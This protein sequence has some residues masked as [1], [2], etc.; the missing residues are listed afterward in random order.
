MTRKELFHHIKE[1]SSYLCVGL[2]TDLSKI[3]KHLLKENDPVF[4]FNKQIIDATID[5]CVGYKPNLAFYE[6]LGASGWESLQKT[7][8]YIPDEL[9]TIA[10]AKRGDIGN[11]AKKYAEAFF[12]RMNFDSVT[13]APYMGRDSVDPFLQYEGKWSIIL[14]LTSNESSTDFEELN[15]ESGIALFE[16]VLSKASS[17]GTDDQL[18]FVIGAT[19]PDKFQLVR[20]TIPNHF[21]LVP[22]IGAQGGDLDSISRIGFND[23]CGLLVNSSR[24]IIYASD[25]KNFG[26]SAKKA[27]ANVQRSMKALLENYM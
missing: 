11:T 21:L 13:I 19:K 2:D 27:A 25:D 14:G 12:E 24:S 6:S 10:D 23:H 20:K 15:L 3:P 1:K 18:M 8:E 17:W 7:I 16:E 4:E 9:F 5:H 22:G 26:A